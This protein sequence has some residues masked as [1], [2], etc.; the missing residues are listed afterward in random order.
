MWFESTS[1]PNTKKNSMKNI[2]KELLEYKSKCKHLQRFAQ[3]FLDYIEDA[4]TEEVMQLLFENSKYIHY[5]DFC[6]EYCP[7]LDCKHDCFSKLR[8]R[9]C[10]DNDCNLCDKRYDCPDKWRQG[11]GRF[12]VVL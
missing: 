11:S 3:A 1:P 6:K 2:E 5:K 4:D 10:E 9:L 7:F 12:E 8:E